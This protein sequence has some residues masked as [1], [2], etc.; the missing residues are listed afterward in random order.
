[1][2]ILLKSQSIFF[3]GK[4]GK[5]TL[6]NLTAASRCTEV[7]TRLVAPDKQEVLTL[8]NTQ[9]ASATVRFKQTVCSEQ[10][11]ITALISTWA[12]W[13]CYWSLLPSEAFAFQVWWLQRILA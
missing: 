6:Q 1:M 13:C 5:F 3:A 10:Q 12:L 4:D 9:A 8:L 7:D 11:E 2:Y